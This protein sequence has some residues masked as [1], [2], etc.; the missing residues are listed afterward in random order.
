MNVMSIGSTKARRVLVLGL[1]IAVA[2]VLGLAAALESNWV[3]LAATTVFA[4]LSVVFAKADTRPSR[5]T[6]A[7]MVVV[8]VAPPAVA[9]TVMVARPM[10]CAVTS[11]SVDTLTICWLLVENSS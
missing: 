9:R 1:V 8:A 10:R 11:P 2:A 4:I 5:A 7:S 6:R 3:V